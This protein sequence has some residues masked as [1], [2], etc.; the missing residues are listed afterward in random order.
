MAGEYT[1]EMIAMLEAQ[2]AHF[3]S[4]DHIRREVAVWAGS[5]PEE[6]LAEAEDMCAEADYFLSQLAPEAL[7]RALQPEP[8][9]ADSAEIFIALRRAAPSGTQP[10]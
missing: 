9:P 6:R 3:A 10:R 8:L 4:D 1:P 5:T 2:I 7:A